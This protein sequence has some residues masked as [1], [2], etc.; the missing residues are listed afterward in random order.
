[1]LWDPPWV[2]T[3]PWSPFPNP[4]DLCLIALPQLPPGLLGGSQ[5]CPSSYWRRGV[6]RVTGALRCPP[7]LAVRS[8]LW[9]GTGPPL[10]MQMQWLLPGAAGPLC[11]AGR[12]LGRRRPAEQASGPVPPHS[13]QILKPLHFFLQDLVFL[14]QP[15]HLIG[16]KEYWQ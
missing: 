4:S 5:W 10:R 16:C 6:A 8:C 1:M 2:S 15:I 13:P 7:R 11:A 3:P 14:P 12:V 9:R